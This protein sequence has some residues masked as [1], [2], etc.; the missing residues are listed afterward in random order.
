MSSYSLSLQAGLEAPLKH[1][2][3]V[4]MIL[5]AKTSHTLPANKCLLTQHTQKADFLVFTCD[6]TPCLYFHYFT[7]PA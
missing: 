7:K 6:L 5:V 4:H 3:D 2:T 1:K